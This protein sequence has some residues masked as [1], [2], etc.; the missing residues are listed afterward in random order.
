MPDTDGGLLNRARRQPWP[1]A[2]HQRAGAVTD[3]LSLDPLV[4]LDDGR[5]GDEDALF[6]V[7]GVGTRRLDGPLEAVDQPLPA[8]AVLGRGRPRCHAGAGA[9]RVG[10]LLLGPGA[11]GMARTTWSAIRNA[12]KPLVLAP[13]VEGAAI[14]IA[15]P[16]PV[17]LTGHLFEQG[18]VF[19]VGLEQLAALL[20]GQ[21]GPGGLPTAVQQA[22]Q[23]S[24]RPA[25]DV[26]WEEL[27][28]ARSGADDRTERSCTWPFRHE[29]P[30]V[31]ARHF[32]QLRIADAQEP[33]HRG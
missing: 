23:G 16:V 10:A 11:S 30:G 24:A 31:V 5:A 14:A 17:G 25:P 22:D 4:V 33:R 13:G 20:G 32:R 2:T 28:H 21:S 12:G 9:R 8:F 1:T 6:E 19:T 29:D 27:A 26:G 15:Q 18:D 7:T 3:V